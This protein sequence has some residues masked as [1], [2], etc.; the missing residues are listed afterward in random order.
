MRYNTPV[1]I[2]G[3]ART[4]S[5]ILTRL[6]TSCSNIHM[7]N[8][9][10]AFLLHLSPIIFNKKLIENFS[11]YRP[12]I[13]EKSQQ[14]IKLVPI[15]TYDELDKYWDIILEGEQYYGDKYWT[16]IYLLEDL[17]DLFDDF[18]LIITIRDPRDVWCSF[19]R[20]YDEDKSE[21]LTNYPTIKRAISANPQKYG[22]DCNITR[23]LKRW[24]DIRDSY[25]S[26]EVR[27]EDMCKSHKGTLKSIAEYLNISYDELMSAYADMFQPTH[28]EAWKEEYPGINQLIPSDYKKLMEEFGY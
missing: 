6:I 12:R 22:G 24:Y 4:G 8:E 15:L 27:Y 21:R 23:V 17:S 5:T 28:L 10:L 9:S 7:T 16:Y 25:D 20:N 11:D 18:K 26:L 1:I 13:R 14:L 2:T 3:G 19:A